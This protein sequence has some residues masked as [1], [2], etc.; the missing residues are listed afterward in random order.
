MDLAATPV[1]IL[2]GGR[3]TRLSP[4]VAGRPK[5]LAPVAGQP[6]LHWL[7][8]DLERQGARHIVLS[9]G[10]LA[11]Q[12]AAFLRDFPLGALSVRT[13]VEP[14]PLGTGGGLRLVAEQLAL[15]GPLC[16]LNG[17]TW[18][19]GGLAEF[20]RQATGHPTLG[21]VAVPDTTRFGRVEL[22]GDRVTAFREK[23]Q[24]GP[25]L[26]HGGLD[27]LPADLLG[28]LPAGPSSLERDLLEPLASAGR[29][30]A[31][32]LSG[33]FVDFGLPDDYK[34]FSAWAERQL[35]RRF[36]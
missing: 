1:V 18:I 4:V 6:F 22:D 20:A 16:V 11:E 21:L 19:E 9:L 31:C 34:A 14:E 29:L 13:V 5:V 27:L 8:R 17:D 2:A 35:P 12:V 32:R 24:G 7:L 33:A 26:I 30:K 15:T 23:G 10:Y 36:A 25:G 3:G 28:R